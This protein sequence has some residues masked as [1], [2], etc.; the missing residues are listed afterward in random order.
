M[1]SDETFNWPDGD[2]ILRATHGTDSRDFR[3]HKLF[4]SFASP[5]FKDTFSLPQPSSAVS[6]VETI[7]VTCPPRALEVILRFVYPSTDSPAINDLTLLSEVLVIADKYEIRAAQSRFRSSLMEFVKTEPLR[8]YAIACRLGYEDEMKIASSHT[9]SIHLPNLTKLPDEFEFVPATAYHRLI[10]LHAKYRKEVEDIVANHPPVLSPVP[11]EKAFFSGIRGALE[12]ANA[13][14]TL[15][16]II[17]NGAPLNYESLAP[18][19]ETGNVLDP[20]VF[21][22]FIH[23]ILDRANALSLTV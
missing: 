14:Q 2:V 18:V 6:N 22:K 5:V 10:L 21:R 4:L 13:R 16:G 23:S 12:A 9:T 20:A 15:L 7:D 11:R 8:V 19:V 3:V 17:R 1:N